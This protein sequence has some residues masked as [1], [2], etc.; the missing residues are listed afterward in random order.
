MTGFPYDGPVRYHHTPNGL[1]V[2]PEPRHGDYPHAPPAPHVPGWLRPD[3]LELRRPAR[4][5]D[6]AAPFLAKLGSLPTRDPDATA[7]NCSGRAIRYETVLADG[8]GR[9]EW[10]SP[11]CFR[12]AHGRQ[13]PLLVDHDDELHVG[14]ARLT[15]HRDGLH[16]VATLLPGAAG[17]IG[18]RRQV[19]CG[20]A[21]TITTITD[22]GV[23]THH[24]GVVIE[25][26]IV[27]TGAHAPHSYV[28]VNLPRPDAVAA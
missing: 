12:S 24:K 25:V 7:G 18:G 21:P 13:V 28:V 16:F 22:R 5:G 27:A 20:F 4:S 8:A 6:P 17:I 15:E 9:L 3:R 2:T 10:F 23:K 1:V 26:S 11:G 14:H 19:S